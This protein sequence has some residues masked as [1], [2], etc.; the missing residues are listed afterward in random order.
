MVISNIWAMTHD[1]NVYPDPFTFK[2][3]RFLNADGKL[4]EDDRILTYG[5]GRRSAFSGQ[6][7]KVIYLVTYYSLVIIEYVRERLLRGMW[8]VF[9]M[10]SSIIIF[11]A[12]YQ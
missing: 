11:G 10:L 8:W 6:T 9:L 5:F 1:E 3:E 7:K 4:N 2:P 12:N